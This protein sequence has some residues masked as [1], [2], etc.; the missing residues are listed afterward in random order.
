MAPWLNHAPH[1]QCNAKGSHLD[2]GS[3]YG[4]ETSCRPATVRNVIVMYYRCTCMHAIIKYGSSRLNHPDRNARHHQKAVH[5]WLLYLWYIR[6]SH[7]EPFQLFHGIRCK[8]TNL[9]F[10]GI[11]S[12]GMQPIVDMSR[13]EG[14]TPQATWG[15]KV[16]LRQAN[17]SELCY[18]QDPKLPYTLE[19]VVFA[20]AYELVSSCN[21]LCRSLMRASL[22]MAGST[23]S[24]SLCW[25]LTGS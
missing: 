20:S 2:H 3:N 5:T 13:R 16:T 9:A 21:C 4:D 18:C 25:V 7:N 11:G 24:L 15:S 22:R 10:I 8:L 6:P 12:L 19:P 14:S 17:P 1:A 23:A